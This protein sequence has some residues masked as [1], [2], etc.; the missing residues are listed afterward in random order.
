MWREA[1]LSSEQNPHH[2]TFLLHL[3]D[4]HSCTSLTRS[5]VV[6]QVT[7]HVARARGL[8]LMLVLDLGKCVG[9]PL[10]SFIWHSAGKQRLLFG[11]VLF[12][13]IQLLLEVLAGALHRFCF[14][15]STLH[16]KAR[17]HPTLLLF[18]EHFHVECI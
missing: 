3:W 10:P 4:A 11:Q 6:T 12:N 15:E 13:L 2:N 1:G 5:A 9:L 7:R 8:L 14:M 18:F 16:R 17:R